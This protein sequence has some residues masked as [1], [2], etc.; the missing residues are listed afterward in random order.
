MI[1]ISQ[2]A[3]HKVSSRTPL[4]D[5]LHHL[6]KNK[7]RL[8]LPVH[9]NGRLA[10]IMTP[11]DLNRWLLAENS[12]SLDAPLI[13]VCNLEPKTATEQTSSTELKQLLESVAYVP[14]LDSEGRPIALAV[15]RHLQRTLTLGRSQIG[16][17]FPTFVIAEIGNNHNGSIDL[18]LRLIDLAKEHG[19]DCA[20]FQMRDLDSLYGQSRVDHCISD[21]LGTQYTLDLLRRFRL[22]PEEFA[23]A[24]DH[25]RD[26]GLTPL[27]T[28]W[29]ESSVKFLEE[30]GLTAYK[31]ASADLTNHRLLEVIART[32][33][34]LICSTGMSREA[35]IQES[36]DLLKH[37][38]AAYMLLHCNSTYPTPF[39]D[40]HLQ[41]MDRLR[42]IGDCE[43]GYSG[44]ERDIFVAVAAV[45][46]GARVIEKHF[47]VDREMEGNDHKISLLPIDFKQMVEGI[48]QV[49]AAMGSAAS[50]ELTQGEFINR[51]TLA[52]SVF[53]NT[54][55]GMGEIIESEMLAVRSPGQGLQPNK[56]QELVGRTAVRA[57]RAGDIFY[58]TDIEP[59]QPKPRDY[60]FT[61]RWGIPV[62]HHDYR[63]LTSL[64]NPRVLEFHLSCRDL[65]LQHSDF[66]SNT[67]PVELIVHAPELF[68]GDHTLDLTSPDVTYRQ[69][70][71]AEMKRVIA[72]VQQL[73]CYFSNELETIGIV[74]NVGGFSQDA[75]LSP[76]EKKLRQTLLRESLDI[77][78]DESVE[79][80]P[81]TM[82]PF[83][84]HFGGQR[85]HNL[86]VNAEDIGE[87]C[88]SLD[89]RV[90]LD[91]SHS[92]LA[93]NHSKLSFQK[94]LES[95]LPY[96]AHIHIADS[97]G[98]DG[99]G[100]QI[101]EG[102]IDFY[103]LG[104]AIQSYA[105][106]ASWI[107]EIWQ[108]HENNGEGFWRALELLEPAL[109][110]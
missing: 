50:R 38:G 14:I 28:P 81:Q 108:G 97:R 104:K 57:M 93:C 99:E 16:K 25:C 92:K 76:K 103:A 66:F 24:F 96:A 17:G 84:W 80:W 61:Q 41:Y 30:Y 7:L 42:E 65:E 67:L 86:F 53:T 18:A 75:P 87:L 3:L 95:V 15:R 48:R 79:I 4:K 34:P 102:E 10:G 83:P 32:G 68:A 63:H 45:A 64:T 55:L 1:I 12:H 40:I 43:V 23:T 13:N 105:P 74:T 98:V 78:R 2:L 37:E 33:K 6:D 107:P 88:Q 70:S 5:A 85:F 19:A 44:H 35:E 91:V 56:M 73:R 52:K 82:P 100:L 89:I 21:N 101:G 9:E 90:C 11:G 8:L 39:K 47:T 60:K 58:P 106:N 71:Q 49:E 26:V 110:A 62:R 77:L 36:V 94:Y 51:A 109:S 54:D 69:K 46:R 27:C 72:V 22:T 29:D 59:N 20:K 31:I